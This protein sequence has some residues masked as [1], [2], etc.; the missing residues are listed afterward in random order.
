MEARG[1]DVQ[2]A[3]DDAQIYQRIDGFGASFTDSSAYLLYGS[4]GAGALSATE[5][6]TVMRALFH[7]TSGIRLSFLRQPIGTSDFRHAYDYS[8]DDM[9][10]GQT[11]YDLS[12]FSISDDLAYI[13]P[14][15]LDALAIN[16]DIFIMGSPWSPPPWMKDSGQFG[17]GRL[18]DSDALYT[19][20]ANYFARYVQAYA[21][22]GITVHAVT[23]QNEPY[24]E[25]G[26]YP[27]MHME[28]AEQARLVK[29]M[30]PVFQAEGI[31]TKIVVWDH[32][33]D[34]WSFPIS[35]LNDSVARPFIAGSAFHCYSGQVGFQSIVHNAY[36]DKALYFTECSGGGWENGSFG[37]LFLLEVSNYIIAPLRNWA[38]SAV[39]WNIALDQNGGPKISGGCGNCRGVITIDSNTGAMTKN[40]EY[41]SLGHAS[42]FVDQGARRI[43][44]SNGGSV[45]NVAFLNPDGSTA[46]IVLNPDAVSHTME[47]AWHGQL[48]S[49]TIGARSVLTFKWPAGF[50]PSAEV[51]RTTADSPSQRLQRMFNVSFTGGSP[52]GDVDGDGDVDLA[53]FA[54]FGACLG[55]PGSASV[56][57]GCSASDF[58]DSDLDAD[59][60]VDATDYA[61]FQKL[62]TTW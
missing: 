62:I 40:P 14:G 49:Y 20:Y 28:P 4:Y 25:P 54:V 8:Y 48:L 9:P 22:L 27:G 53:D 19:T 18:L 21:A 2:I 24:F 36:P 26:S 34:N 39:L 52:P 41:F 12:E 35:V 61:T 33:W 37:D 45:Q 29:K 15:L 59:G 50:R 7:P 56:P 31:S 47:L 38:Q 6:D 1:A 32:N 51:W 60:D 3:I 43:N 10:S 57:A 30:G 17:W 5:R 46:A 16:P 55:G 23:L 58:A 13:V 44:S 42:R 11:D